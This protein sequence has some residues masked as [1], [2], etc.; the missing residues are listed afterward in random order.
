MKLIYLNIGL[1]SVFDSQVGELLRAYEKMGE[2]ESIILLYGWKKRSEIERIMG[3][4]NDSNIKLV[5]FRA[6]PNYPVISWF[7]INSMAKELKKISG[8]DSYIF[9]VRGEVSGYYALLA[10]K[11]NH[12]FKPR[13][14]VDIRGASIEEIEIYSP[15]PGLL[16]RLKI[17]LNKTALSYLKRKE[18]IISAVSQ[19]LK[20]YL[21]KREFKDDMITVNH[22]IVGAAFHFDQEKRK[23][24]RDE[25]GLTD[26]DI[27]IVFSS[28]GEA[29]WQ[30]E[31][32]IN[33]IIKMNEKFVILNLSK[34]EI[35]HK[36]V[37]NKL[38]TYQE[39]ADYLCA[40]DYG[41][42]IR[43]NNI[44]NQVACPVKLVEYI[45]CGLSIIH[46]ASVKI[47]DDYQ[48]LIDSSFDLN[49]VL[50]VNCVYPGLIRV[51]K[52]KAASSLFEIE[53]IS[54]NYLKIFQEII[55][56]YGY[57][58]HG[59]RNNIKLKG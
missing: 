45:S 44:V 47:M 37:I 22:C 38:V 12:L 50:K 28:G 59:E 58:E 1:S 8:L 2:F 34:K 23:I 21:I 24:K 13:M 30:N 27:C 5:F 26:D 19:E 55:E 9:H 46:N 10:L 32:V 56:R 3:K 18:V 53:M 7:T 4:F 29:K 16:K 49:S 52:S 36:R 54:G 11:K 31:K 48:I 57:L 20:N 40:A 6:F 35:N 43:D 15:L 33:E 51:A 42:L 17:Y 25:L 41:L 14:L 39:V